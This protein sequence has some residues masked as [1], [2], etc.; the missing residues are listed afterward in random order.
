MF[1]PES[2][3]ECSGKQF[4]KLAALKFKGG[5]EISCQVKALKILCGFSA[6]RFALLNPYVINNALPF[7]DWVFETEKNLVKQLIPHYRRYHGPVSD[8]DNLKMNE[9]HMSEL[10]FREI[11]RSEG[12]VEDSLNNLIASIYRLPKKKYDKKRDPDGDIRVKFNHNEIP[13]HAK[14]IAKWPLAVKHAILLWYGGCRKALEE[15]NPLV[16]KDEGSDFESQ[17]DTGMYGI[18]RNLAGDKLGSIDAIEE[19]Y[20]K[21][22]MLEIGLIKEE[23]KYFE[24]K[25]K[26]KTA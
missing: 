19:M 5:D 18:M 20:V 16:F 6:F 26:Q 11:T 23:E 1:L 3:E 25:M 10:Y 14:R 17:F 9:F 15:N 24:Q 12:N 21:T 2:F 8:F 7:V 13:F 4:I 22:C